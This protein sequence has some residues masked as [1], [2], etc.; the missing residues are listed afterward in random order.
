MLP[1]PPPVHRRGAVVL[2]VNTDLGMSKGKIAAQS[3]HAAVGVLLDEPGAL[4]DPDV[5]AWQRIGQAKVA[6]KVRDFKIPANF[7]H[8]G[9]SELFL[10]YFCCPHGAPVSTLDR[11]FKKMRFR[12]DWSNIYVMSLRQASQAEMEQVAKLA[13]QA[14]IRTYTVTD[15][16]RTQIAAGSRTVCAIGPAGVT[17]I[18]T[19]TGRGGAVPLKLL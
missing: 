9:G 3:A 17:A 7:R 15:A 11:A 6:L 5:T 16:G 4:A 10:S 14:G 2:V 19:I 12:A 13:R 1:P 8:S 18:D